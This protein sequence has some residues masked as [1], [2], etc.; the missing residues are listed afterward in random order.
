MH[1]MVLLKFLR[2][3]PRVPYALLG[4]MMDVPVNYKI[5]TSPRSLIVSIASA[6]LSMG[7]PLIMQYYMM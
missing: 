3:R 5:V 1:G 6:K 7:S 4:I 2:T